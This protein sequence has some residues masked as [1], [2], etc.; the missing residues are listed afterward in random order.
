MSETNPT[1]TK[2]GWTEGPYYVYRA[3]DGEAVSVAKFVVG[4]GG[5]T[6]GK[7]ICRMPV[8][9]TTGHLNARTTQAEINA[10]AKLLAASPALYA[11]LEAMVETYWRGSED[12]DD[13]DAPECV[14]LALAAL[15]AANPARGK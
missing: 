9:K 3:E 7:S 10:T 2:P 14:K 12:S 5:G 1:P 11:A 4:D 13:A 8:P 6:T 15:N